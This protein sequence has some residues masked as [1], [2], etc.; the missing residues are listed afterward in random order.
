MQEEEKEKDAELAQ[1]VHNA[2]NNITDEKSVSDTPG[3][4]VP[5]P[6][7]PSMNN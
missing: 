4:A 2:L 3:E 1:K 5:A 7:G 6:T